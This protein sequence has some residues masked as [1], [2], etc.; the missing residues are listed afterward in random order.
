MN[1][2]ANNLIDSMILMSQEHSVD[3]AVEKMQNFLKKRNAEYRWQEI[4]KAIEI[5]LQTVTS[6]TTKKITTANTNIDPL[7]NGN[8]SHD[9]NLIGGFT[10]QDSDTLI[11]G[12]LS[13]QLINLKQTLT[14]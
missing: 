9:E 8:A 6:L 3:Y 14:N 7:V 13:T 2:S 10:I 4:I 12:S 5:R 11:D 1:Y